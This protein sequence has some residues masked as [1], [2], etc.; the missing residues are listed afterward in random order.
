MFLRTKY[1][2]QK[3]WW[4]ELLDVTICTADANLMTNHKDTAYW[5]MK[6]AE[7]VEGTGQFVKAATLYEEI[8]QR[9]SDYGGEGLKDIE[10]TLRNM[11]AALVVP[12][13]IEQKLIAIIS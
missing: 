12:S 2:E 6:V 5:C 4:K 7:A 3:N 1:H 10:E 8:S 11:D 9:H 13:F